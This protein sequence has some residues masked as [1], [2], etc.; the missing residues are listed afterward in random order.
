M[1]SD[2]VSSLLDNPASSVA[3]TVITTGVDVTIV[4]PP[5]ATT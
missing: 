2:C 3:S 1:T 4:S 5:A